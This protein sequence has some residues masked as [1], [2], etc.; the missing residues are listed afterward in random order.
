VSLPGTI[1][2]DLLSLADLVLHEEVHQGAGDLRGGESGIEQALNAV[3]VGGVA[4]SFEH[5]F[6]LLKGLD[7]R[8]WLRVPPARARRARSMRMLMKRWM[9]CMR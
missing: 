3:L 9:R 8:G 1:F 2:H 7:P 6:D 5:G 4:G